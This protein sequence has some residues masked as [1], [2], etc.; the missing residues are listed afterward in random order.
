MKPVS[1]LIN[2]Y[3]LAGTYIKTFL[4]NVIF[5]SPD[6]AAFFAL[7]VAVF[8][9][10][11]SEQYIK[12]K[13]CKCHNKNL[14]VQKQNGT[15]VAYNTKNQNR[16]FCSLNHKMFN[17]TPVAGKRLSSL[18]KNFLFFLGLNILIICHKSF[19]GKVCSVASK[20][21]ISTLSLNISSHNICSRIYNCKNKQRQTYKNY[22]VLYIPLTN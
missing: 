20:P 22:K 3:I 5:L 9:C 18:T 17:A 19:M 2:S 11:S 21:C 16:K 13:H 7:A 15:S 14:P 1:Q 6:F 8:N 12:N 4:H 10:M